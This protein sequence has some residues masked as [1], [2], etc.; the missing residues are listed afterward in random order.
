MKRPF[1][2]AAAIA[3][4]LVA[5]S[6]AQAGTFNFVCRH[7][8]LGWSSG[9]H[10]SCDCGR[11]CGSSCVK[12]GKGCHDMQVEVFSPGMC[13]GSGARVSPKYAPGPV[14]H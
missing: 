6:T 11:C 5:G 14:K 8:G 9:Y 3:L 13:F 7:L 4:S 1:I 12:G 10:A 2:L